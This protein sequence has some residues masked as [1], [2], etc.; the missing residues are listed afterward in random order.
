M[1]TAPALPAVL[2]LT[3]LPCAG[4]TTLAR[5][6]QERLQQRDYPVEWLDGDR[7][8]ESLPGIGFSPAERQNYLRHMGF[9]ASVLERHG[10][11]TIASFVSPC[12][13]H[14]AAARELCR[15]FIEIYVSTPL[16]ECERRDVKGMYK[17]ARAGRISQFTG[18]DD[19]YEIPETPELR[20]DTQKSP[21]AECV[22]QILR[23]LGLQQDSAGGA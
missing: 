23:R 22:E 9:L 18:V 5:L 19:P 17:L 7:V 2:W 6:L 10:I 12:R 21:P 13:S 15:N 11:T 20:L 3:G 4:K 14:R 16:T 1:S 8:R